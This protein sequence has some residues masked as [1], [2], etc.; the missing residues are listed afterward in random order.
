[1]H[2]LGFAIVTALV[3]LWTT[4]GVA[5][6][7]DDL[8]ARQAA[9]ARYLSVVPLAKMLD[10]MYDAVATNIPP[11]QREEFKKKMSRVVRLDALER[12]TLDALVQTFTVDELDALAEFYGSKHGASAMKKFG[13]YMSAIMPPLLQEMQRALREL[14]A[15]YQ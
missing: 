1:M 3:L 4:A 12:I 14:Q 7:E 13:A 15:S 6:A 10:D 11:D 2:R 5:S 8:A 9:A